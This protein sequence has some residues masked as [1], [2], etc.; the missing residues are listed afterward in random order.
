[1]AGRDDQNNDYG[2]QDDEDTY[3]Y[4]RK[5]GRSRRGPDPDANDD[6]IYDISDEDDMS[7]PEII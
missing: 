6:N 2:Y 1:M 4:N 5:G 7:D 3:K